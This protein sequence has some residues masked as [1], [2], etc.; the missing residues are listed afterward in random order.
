MNEVEVL[1]RRVDRERQ[2]RLQAEAIMEKKASEL[3]EASEKLRILNEQLEQ[4]VRERTLQLRESE[5]K[6]RGII[7]NMELGLLE[8]NNND[9][10]VRAYSRFCKIVG[11]EAHELLGKKASDIFLDDELRPFL[12]E[13]NELRK[14][15]C[16]ECV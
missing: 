4:Q 1:K 6:Y 15:R 2:A 9:E 10:I 14:N 3:F 16:Y 5:E 13:Q 12:L 8:V 7:E 11:Y